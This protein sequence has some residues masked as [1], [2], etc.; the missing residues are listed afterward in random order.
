MRLAIM[1][2]YFL[3]IGY[4]QLMSAVDAFVV[5]DRI[6]VHQKGWISRPHVAER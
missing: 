1:Q 5:Y 6:K 2:P 3:P 4:W